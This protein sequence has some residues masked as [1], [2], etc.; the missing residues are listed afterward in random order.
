MVIFEES[1]L[2][3]IHL[4]DVQPGVYFVHHP[5]NLLEHERLVVKTP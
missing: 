3:E 1:S 4:V 5:D 2:A